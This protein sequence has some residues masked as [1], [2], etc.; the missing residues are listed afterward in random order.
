[1]SFATEYHGDQGTIRV[2]EQ[3]AE[4]LGSLPEE[5]PPL[6]EAIDP[7][8]LDAIFN[9]ASNPVTVTFSYCGCTVTMTGDRHVTIEVAE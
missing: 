5:L 8:A 7:E 4:K 1:M 2:V 6:Y 3:V 9:S